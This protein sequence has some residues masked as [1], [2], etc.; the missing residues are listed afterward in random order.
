MDALA[1]RL[2]GRPNNAGWGI[3][4][5]T[6]HED[7]VQE[8]RRALLLVLGAVGF[9]M[10]IVCANV[11]N[12]VLARSTRRLKESALRSALGASRTRLFRQML[13]ESLLLAVTGGVLGVVVAQWTIAPLIRLA[14]TV[15]PRLDGVRLDG[16]VLGF[17]VGV[18]LLTGL[19]FSLVPTLL[20]SRAEPGLFLR[21]AGTGVGRRRQRLRATL[22]VA[23]V[24]L[25]MVLLIG[26]GLM[27]RSF[28]RL[29]GVDPGFAFENIMTASLGL[30]ASRYESA[31]RQ[32][33]FY[34]RL[35]EDLAAL[36][37]VESVG[38]T[39][40][41][42]MSGSRM[43]FGYRIEG[44]PEDAA[45]GRLVAEYHATSADY[46]RTM[47]IEFTS[48]RTFTAAESG[49]RTKAV[50]I[51]QTLAR[52]RF[53]GSTPVGERITVV[54]QGGPTSREIVG[55]IADVKHA[56]PAS[57]PR[58]EVYVPL[59]DDPWR[60]ATIVLDVRGP[61][62]GLREA[63][64]A[65]LSAIDPALP[66]SSAQPMRQLIAG[67]LAP[68]RFQMLLVGLF[69]VVAL[70]LAGV[71]IYGVIA[72]IVGART[73]EIGVR[74]ALGAGSGK[75]FRL[76]LGQGMAL[77]GLGAA[78][79]LVGALALSRLVRSLLFDVTPYDPMTFLSITGV[80]LLVAG[81]ASY[82]PAR[83]ATRVDAVSALKTE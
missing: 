14:P 42:P 50:V 27:T 79:G 65:R 80:V 3:A 32:S 24:A 56:G 33:A 31:E 16:A 52:R 9:V 59:G 18:S 47:H 6:L 38:A 13:T 81:V 49:G 17:S 40:N 68:L 43:T 71:G 76:F 77:A 74:M 57:S 12:L 29:R 15:I 36:D 58:E 70:A 62:G 82:L 55:V 23:E 69:A 83:R 53:P 39:T 30:P 61:E 20:A 78:L 64:Q 35:L 54:S 75:I 63:I 60:F 37:G 7:M 73:N 26:A 2:E 66:L 34:A 21:V 1:R 67:W 46:F 48:G 8:H 41:L 11:A 44:R 5:R 72:Y 10:L 19:L 28:V 4:L 22:I 51:N 45:D 25:S